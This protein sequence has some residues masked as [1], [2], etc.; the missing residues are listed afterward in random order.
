M[1]RQAARR[2]LAFVVEEARS[3]TSGAMLSQ[4]SWIRQGVSCIETTSSV[5]F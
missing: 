4:I 1:S 3:S 5:I 2:F